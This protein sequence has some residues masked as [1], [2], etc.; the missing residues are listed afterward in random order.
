MNP[1]F[2]FLVIV[3]AIILWFLLS[4]IFIPLGSFILRWLR[5]IKE[6]T[7]YDGNKENNEGEQNE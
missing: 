3:A 7:E 5:E 6:I 2:I 1:V 4:F